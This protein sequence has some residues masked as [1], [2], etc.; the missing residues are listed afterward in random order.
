[1][2]R[3]R[4]PDKTSHFNFSAFVAKKKKRKPYHHRCVDSAHGAV[5]ILIDHHITYQIVL[6]MYTASASGRRS[7][8]VREKRV[9]AGALGS[10]GHRISQR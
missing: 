9:R 4:L 8:V 10:R 2:M 7:R 1:M 5:A 3:G 6:S